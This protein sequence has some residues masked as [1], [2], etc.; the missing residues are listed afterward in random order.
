MATMRRMPQNVD[1]LDA[2]TPFMEQNGKT[3][4]FGGNIEIDGDL[5]I[6]GRTTSKGAYNLYRHVVKA[7][8]TNAADDY[9]MLTITSR[10]SLKIDSLTDL[11]VF[12]GNN[13]EY[14][15]SGRYVGNDTAYVRMTQSDI[16]DVEGNGYSLS[17]YTF[18]DTVT[19]L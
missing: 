12:L 8:D 18:T 17:N 10:N 1:T 5:Q 13:F 16:Y 2:V 19:L 9:F 4:V 6:N 3:T 15:V 11:K 14:P 7:T